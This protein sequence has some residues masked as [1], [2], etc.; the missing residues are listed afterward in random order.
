[1]IRRIGQGALLVACAVFLRPTGAAAQSVF[2]VVTDDILDQPI[3]LVSLEFTSLDPNVDPL[4]VVT[5][6]RG[7]F[8]TP[9]PG[10]G[11]YYL[12]TN[13]LR[14]EP[15]L[16][17]PIEVEDD[18]ERIE[19]FIELRPRPAV[20]EGISVEVRGG[21]RREFLERNGFYRRQSTG[22]GRYIGPEDLEDRRYSYATAFRGIPGVRISQND[23]IRFTGRGAGLTSGGSSGCAPHIYVDGARLYQGFSLRSAAPLQDIDAVEVYR[24]AFIPPE[25]R[26]TRDRPCGVVLIWTRG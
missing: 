19:L 3:E 5:D 6:E 2:G 1:M 14:Y 13:H 25:Y 9:L 20:L 17:G 23:G 12:E 21:F 24:G 10:P 8:R 18:S 4:I 26:G 22:Q 16:Y 7:R 11:S 15:V